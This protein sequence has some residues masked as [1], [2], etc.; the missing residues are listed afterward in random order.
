MKQKD[1]DEAIQEINVGDS[2][3]L[4]VRGNY[5]NYFHRGILTAILNGRVYLD[6]GASH[7]SQRIITIK[8]G[9]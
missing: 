9:C 8:K 4:F 3:T 2:V 7:A 5:Q 1:F 6:T